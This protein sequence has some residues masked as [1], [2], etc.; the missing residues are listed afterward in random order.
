MRKTHCES[1]N[2][3]LSISLDFRSLVLTPYVTTVLGDF[4]AGGVVFSL[5]LFLTVEKVVRTKKN[6]MIFSNVVNKYKYI[7]MLDNNHQI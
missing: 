2:L 3:F 6:S 4:C 1:F 5:L 7:E